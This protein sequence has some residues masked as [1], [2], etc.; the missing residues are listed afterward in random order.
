MFSEYGGSGKY[1][2][3]LRNLGFFYKS[4]W[5][6][7]MTDDILHCTSTWYQKLT[8]NHCIYA[9]LYVLLDETYEEMLGGT[10]LECRTMARSKDRKRYKPA[11]NKNPHV[12]YACNIITFYSFE[13]TAL[14]MIRKLPACLLPS[15]SNLHHRYH[16]CHPAYDTE[17]TF[18]IIQQKLESW[19]KS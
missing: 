3:Y 17:E 4:N 14:W 16:I 8:I 9:H 19:N 13:I 11:Q 15:V 2:I 12:E 10:Y 6:L 18:V 7:S 5:N 1:L